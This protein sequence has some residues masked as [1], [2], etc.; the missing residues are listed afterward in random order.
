M[1]SAASQDQLVSRGVSRKLEGR[2]GALAII[3]M[4]MAS[5]APL[6]TVSATVP[7]GLSI[8]N[9]AAFPIM[10]VGVMVLMLLFSVGFV[11]MTPHV[12][13][14]GAFYSY[15]SEGIGRGT[16]IASSYLAIFS[17][18]ILQIAVHA[19][20]GVVLSEY[21]E[22][23]SGA[24]IPWWIFTLI[25]LVI[26][27]FLGYRNIDLSAKVLGIILLGE[28]LICFVF[29]IVVT[30]VGGGPEGL[31]AAPI[32][33]A[34]IFSGAPALGLMFAASGSFGFEAAALYRDEARR[35]EK[36]IPRAVY[37]SVIAIG[38][39]FFV[40]SW[41]MVN[42]WGAEGSLE[43]A[44]TASS[45][46]FTD[47]V[48]MFLGPVGHV[49]VQLL[50]LAST[51]ATLLAL[52]NMITRYT[53]AMANSGVLTPKLGVSHEK[54]KSPAR[55]SLTQ[56]VLAAAVILVCIALGLDPITQA[57][58][59]GITISSVGLLILILATCVAIVVFFTRRRPDLRHSVWKCVVAPILG[60][61]GLAF[62]VYITISDMPNSYGGSI[63]LSLGFLAAMVITIVAGYIHAARNS[64]ANTREI[65]IQLIGSNE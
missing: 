1:N 23:V 61:I 4:F 20:M 27:G 33:P 47:A 42:A 31:T 26:V 25:V 11:A 10:Y 45:T 52:H 21:I 6:T 48:D 35:P 53:F 8:A 59:W 38:I 62:T 29:A 49:A 2:L 60:G 63:W 65:E 17:Y 32:I 51:F 50:L 64:E 30:I 7:I 41:S 39:T 5:A 9:G 44:A 40:T 13:R 28:V 55:A 3:F 54:H 16:G 18:N 12:K 57:F 58:T 46:M 56:S 37:G 19:F 14:A 24:E 34:E 22:A 36:T 15:I 43:R